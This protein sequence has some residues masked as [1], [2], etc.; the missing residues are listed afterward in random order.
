MK[1]KTITLLLCAVLLFSCALNAFAAAPVDRFSHFLVRVPWTDGQFEDVKSGDWY[2]DALVSSYKMGIIKGSSDSTFSPN[3]DI[4]IAETI[5]IAASINSLFHTADTVFAE[6]DPWYR[7]YVDYALGKRII[8][9]E[10]ADYNKAATRGEF[11]AIMARALPPE[12]LGQMNVIQSSSIPDVSYSS[13]YAGPVY[14]LYRAG[15]LTGCDSKGSFRPDRSITRAE[16]AVIAARIMNETQRREFTL[17]AKEKPIVDGEAVFRDCSNAV[18]YLEM[19]D[20]ENKLVANASGFFIDENGTAVT[21]WHAI[22]KGVSAKITLANTGEK[23]DVEGIYDFDDDN[24]WAVIKVK[25]SGFEYLEIGD[26]SSVVGGSTVYALGSPLGLQNTITQGLICNPLRVED[27]TKFI[28][29]SAAI[30]SGSSGGALINKYGQVI[31]ITAASYVYGESLNLAVDIS[32]IDR[33]VRGG[34]M[35]RDDCIA[36]M[37]KEAFAEAGIEP[38]APAESEK[39][40]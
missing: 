28:L 17:T 35:S 25:G 27:G 40:E 37:A 33:A 10:F 8:T 29:F 2:Y 19:F 3:S 15:I 7:S 26:S 31:G 22:N 4:T 21:C 30:S 23:F 12:L 9:Q 14:L 34:L 5:K 20:A 6:S 16:A 38:E 1:K 11:A 36:L 24:D 13:Y 39:D 18:F 32:Y